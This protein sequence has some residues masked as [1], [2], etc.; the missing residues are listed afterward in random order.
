MPLPLWAWNSRTF[1]YPSPAWKTC[2]FI[3]PAGVCANELEDVP[4]IIGSRRTRGPAESDAPGVSDLPAASFVCFYFRARDGGQRLHACPL[5]EALAS[6]H[7]GHQHAVYRDLG[8]R[9]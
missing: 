9:P 7:H 1:I 3:T 4:G 5:Q 6:R 8:L 2:S